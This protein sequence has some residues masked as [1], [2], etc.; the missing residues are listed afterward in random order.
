MTLELS[1]HAHFRSSSMYHTCCI[2]LD[3]I[4]D[5]LQNWLYK[6]EKKSA[7]LDDLNSAS[8]TK[9]KIPIV[10]AMKKRPLVV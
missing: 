2:S 9:T 8:K 3:S 1:E 4:G 6:I 7:T 10:G 5:I